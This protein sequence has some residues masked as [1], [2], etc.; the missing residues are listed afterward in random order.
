MLLPVPPRLI[1]GRGAPTTDERRHAHFADLSLAVKHAGERYTPKLVR[2]AQ[3]PCPAPAPHPR[4]HQA[5]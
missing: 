2:P 1:D 5:A 3:A 4:G